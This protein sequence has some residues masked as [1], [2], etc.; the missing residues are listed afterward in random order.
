MS[1]EE[2][3]RVTPIA[4]RPQR[5]VSFEKTKYKLFSE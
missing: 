1:E 4:A 2:A 3:S 5:D